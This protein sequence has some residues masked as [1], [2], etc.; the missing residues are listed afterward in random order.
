MNKL[1]SWLLLFFSTGTLLCCALPSLLVVL[2]MGATMAGLISTVPQIIWFSKYKV[3]IFT[4]SGLMIAA[5]AYMQ[6]RA[7][8]LSCPTDKKQAQACSS[9]RIWT[10]R[11]F[12]ISA[13]LWGM[14]AFF[15]FIAPIVLN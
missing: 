2:G 15:A 1:F 10:E 8:F 9:S 12:W 6:R 11:V 14:G 3:W 13:I 5:S 4:V 7:K